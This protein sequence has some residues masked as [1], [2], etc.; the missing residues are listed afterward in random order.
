MSSSLSR[1][2]RRLQQRESERHLKKLGDFLG[3]FYTF[4]EKKDKPSDQAVRDKFITLERRWKGYCNANE[5]N[6]KASSLF[7]RE[8]ALSWRNRYAVQKDNPEN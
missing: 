1:R 6:D 7:N 8:V 2:R 5:L 4:L 3:E